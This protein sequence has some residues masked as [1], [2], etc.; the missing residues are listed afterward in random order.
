MEQYGFLPILHACYKGE[1]VSK[2][3]N[4]ISLIHWFMLS[5]HFRI[6]K[7]EVRNDLNKFYFYFDAFF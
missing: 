2:G 1:Y 7:D 6:K 5:N 3:E 4:L